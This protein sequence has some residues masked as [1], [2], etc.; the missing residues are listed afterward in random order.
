[1]GSS[2]IAFWGDLFQ[3]EPPFHFKVKIRED[4]SAWVHGEIHLPDGDSPAVLVAIADS[5]EATCA[6]LDDDGE[7]GLSMLTMQF[8]HPSTSNLVRFVVVPIGEDIDASETYSVLIHLG[9]RA[10]VTAEV[11]VRVT[12]ERRGR[13]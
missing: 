12:P 5:A 1:V 8:T 13:G 3:P 10:P 11:E 9:E 2:D 6:D 4:G 7:V